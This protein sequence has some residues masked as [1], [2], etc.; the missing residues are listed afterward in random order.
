MPKM[1]HKQAT[2]QA[3]LFF[4]RSKA[5]KQH[6]IINHRQ[7]LLNQKNEIKQLKMV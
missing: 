4:F 7:H 6:V 5:V 2:V 1:K 3:P